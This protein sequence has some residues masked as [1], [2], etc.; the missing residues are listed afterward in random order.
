LIIVT[1]G[2]MYMHQ[3]DTLNRICAA[4][5]AIEARVLVLTGLELAPNEI[6][7]QPNIEVAEYVPHSA[8]FPD[9]SVVVTHAGMGTV[10]A[11]ATAG[12]PIV[13]LPL[14]R[15]QRRNAQRAEELGFAEVLSAAA[16]PDLI[17]ATVERVLASPQRRAAAQSLARTIADYGAGELAITTIER[18]A[19]ASH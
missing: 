10:V 5:S 2:T 17:R 11:A 9:A 16:E 7:S 3:E 6:R 14:G 1:L 8:L 12:V 15:D 13:C 4:L 19:R 18:V